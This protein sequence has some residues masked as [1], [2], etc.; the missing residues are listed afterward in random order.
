M[1]RTGCNTLEQQQQR[2]PHFDSSQGQCLTS[3]RQS[4]LGKPSRAGIPLR[5]PTAA[6]GSDKQPDL[7]A[8]A[9]SRS[10]HVNTGAIFTKSTMNEEEAIQPEDA[11]DVWASTRSIGQV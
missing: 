8:S 4:H 10:A 2:L 1:C 7:V 3:Q 6:L 5:S 11:K 9:R